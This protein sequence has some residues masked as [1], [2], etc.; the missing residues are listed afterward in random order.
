MKNIK[1]VSDLV[2]AILQKYPETRN[3]DMLLYY[4]VTESISFKNDQ[5][6]LAQ[7]F[8]EVIC[9][10]ASYDLPA[11]ETVRRTRQKV[12]QCFPELSGSER[13]EAMRTVNEEEYK[14][15]ARMVTV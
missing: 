5:N 12:Q 6:I 8:G 2:K 9:N 1:N 15:Y 11:F 3:S 10:L 14:N 13:V 7:P 4:R